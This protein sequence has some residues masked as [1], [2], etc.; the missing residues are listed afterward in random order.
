M[1]KDIS[2][3]SKGAI[4]RS[5]TGVPKSQHKKYLRVKTNRKTK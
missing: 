3:L 2:T 4:K 1:L 5:V